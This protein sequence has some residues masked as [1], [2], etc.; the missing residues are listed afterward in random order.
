MDDEDLKQNIEGLSWKERLD[1]SF[2]QDG[3]FVTE[4]LIQKTLQLIEAKEENISQMEAKEEAISQNEVRKNKKKNFHRFSYKRVLSSAAVFFLC[5]IGV[6]IFFKDHKADITGTDELSG[7]VYSTYG[8]DSD[9]GEAYSLFADEGETVDDST[10]TDS[11]MILED[12]AGEIE[13]NA[14]VDTESSNPS[15]KSTQLSTFSELFLTDF[16]LV[17]KIVWKSQDRELIF[18]D[19]IEINEVIALLD[20]YSLLSAEG[21]PLNEM[22]YELNITTEQGEVNLWL[23]QDGGKMEYYRNREIVEEYNV[24]ISEISLLIE[25]LNEIK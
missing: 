1:A 3:I 8:D 20:Q 23:G 2:D 19:E 14:I 17:S 21:N 6:Q 13:E 5:L 11:I 24:T 25:K 15:A 18:D 4:N 9:S 22:I 12:S 10:G 16:G 7:N